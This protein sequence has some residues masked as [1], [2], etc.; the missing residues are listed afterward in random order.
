MGTALQ[1]STD[2]DADVDVEEE[3][4]EGW[5]EDPEEEA[6]EDDEL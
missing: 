1:L 5:A 3:D 2:P 6:A 4:D